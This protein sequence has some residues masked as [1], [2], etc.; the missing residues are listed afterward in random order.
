MTRQFGI[1]RRYLFAGLTALVMVSASGMASDSASAQ[2]PSTGP[3]Q[4]LVA[5][6]AGGGTD[7]LARLLAPSLSKIL[8]RPV[9]VQNMPGGGGQVAATTLLRDGGDGSAIMATNE[10]DLSMSTVFASPSYKLNDFQH[11]MVDVV[12]PR[13]ILVKNDS[14]IKTLADLVS[15]AKAE[16]GKLAVSVAQGSAQELLAKWLFARLGIGVRI[17]GY[18]GGAAAANAMLSGD[19][20]ANIGDDSARLPYRDR[21]RAIVVGGESKSARWPEAQLLTEALAPF[22]ITLP[23]P[24]FLTRYGVYTVPA[25]FKA[26]FPAAYGQLQKAMIEARNSDEFK[27]FIAKNRLED[28][29][30]G[31]PGEAFDASFKAD[32]AEIVKLR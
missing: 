31:K 11:I 24:G 12:D 5:Y 25:A 4:I 29:S 7:S 30:I 28:L 15:R 2:Q 17:V 3:V 27:A 23:S 32:A 18:N 8:G 21:A 16:P 13:I 19:V 10:P 6:G 1:P 9:V 20:V 22:G 14:E 26:K